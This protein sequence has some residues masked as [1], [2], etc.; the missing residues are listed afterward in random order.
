MTTSA[1][2]S[3]FP[4]ADKTLEPANA[5]AALAA[6]G[7][8]RPLGM[9][10]GYDLHITRAEEWPDAE[11]APITLDDWLDY[12]R[13]D[14][15][16][17]MEQA[18]R[19]ATPDGETIEVALHGLVVWT[20][21]SQHSEPERMVYFWHSEDCVDSR[22]ID[23]EV[24]AKLHRIAQR[25]GARVW[26]TMVR[27]MVQ[28][29]CLLRT[30]CRL[31]LDAGHGGGGSLEAP[32]VKCAAGSECPAVRYHVRGTRLRSRSRNSSRIRRAVWY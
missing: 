14:S 15:E 30:M 32:S 23:K 31:H 17:R 4:P 19:T 25:L 26:A 7:Q 21:W 8:R 16:L 24:T 28:M 13:C 18:A 6:Q 11:A 29:E 5:A 1:D 3:A 10:M 9:T 22:G 20:G 27:S 2:D 12:V